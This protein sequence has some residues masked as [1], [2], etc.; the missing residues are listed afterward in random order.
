MRYIASLKDDRLWVCRFDDAAKYAQERDSSAVSSLFVD[1][2]II[3]TLT[4]RMD[5][6]LFD[7]P[8]TV[9]VHL[10]D[11]AKSCSASQAGKSVSVRL[12][13]HEGKTYALVNAVPDRGAVILEGFS[14]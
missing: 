10:P 2:K 14:P 11:G 8:L 3:L 1:K 13:A 9:K 4:D 5:D 6:R 7:Y 12:V